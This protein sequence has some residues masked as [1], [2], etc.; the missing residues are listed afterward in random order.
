MNH[1]HCTAQASQPINI[2]V[3]QWGR[4]GGG[5]RFAIGLAEGLRTVSGAQVQLSLSAQAEILHAANPPDCNWR[6]P[7]Y[8]TPASFFRRLALAPL[9][10][11]GLTRRLRLTRPDMVICAMAGPLDLLMVAAVQ[12]AGSKFALVVHDATPH[13]GDGF[14]GQAALQRMLVRRADALIVLT[15]HVGAGLHAQGLVGAKPLI[16]CPH[17]PLGFGASPPPLGHGGRFRLL[18]LGRMR[19]YKGLDLLAAALASLGPRDDVEIRV[20][21]QGPE[22]PELDALRAHANVSVENRWVPEDELA[23]LLAWADGIVLPYWEAS[24]S[25]IAAAALGAGR[26]VLATQVGGLAEQ[27]A[28]EPAAALCAPN[29]AALAAGLRDLLDIRRFTPLPPR[30][31]PLAAWQAS[32]VGLVADLRQV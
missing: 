29:P 8:S 28:G 13:P 3:W 11:L 5:P 24:Q 32:L 15:N 1:F 6:V 4:R 7:T 23:T 16:V 20:V 10:L 2:L 19:P 26:Y 17:P 30:P 25:G 27:L 18:S 9:M 12:R 22:A 31:D 14:P 21:G